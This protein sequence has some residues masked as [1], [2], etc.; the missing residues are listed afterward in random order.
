M[1]GDG[2]GIIARFVKVFY[3]FFFVKVDLRQLVGEIFG[4][5]EIC[6]YLATALV[7]Q[8]GFVDR[9]LGLLPTGKCFDVG[10]PAL[11]VLVLVK[12]KL[13]SF[14]E[15]GGGG[16]R[17]V[18]D[19]WFRTWKDPFAGFSKTGIEDRRC[20]VPLWRFSVENRLVCFS[21]KE[22]L[23][24]LHMEN[25]VQLLFE[26]Q[27][28][29]ESTHVLNQVNV[30]GPEPDRSLPKQPSVGISASL[31]SLWIR[32]VRS[33]HIGSVHQNGVGLGEDE[34]SIGGR[35]NSGIGVNLNKVCRFVLPS[36]VVD[37][38]IVVLFRL[39]DCILE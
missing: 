18:D 9:A 4:V 21:S 11:E 39:L 23:D 25:G 3:A 2:L 17:N 35:W 29:G 12:R 34:V 6:P 36:E 1:D 27:G 30:V 19:A 14:V 38:V 5:V 15:V 10:K 28:N 13:L 20:F 32:R 7:G 26:R 16:D 8:Q 33:V 22:G 24:D 37:I 31:E